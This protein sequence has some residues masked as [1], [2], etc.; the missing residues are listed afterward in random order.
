MQNRRLR[1]QIFPAPEKQRSTETNAHNRKIIMLEKFSKLK[2]TKL[3]LHTKAVLYL[4]IKGIVV[5]PV[6]FQQ[7]LLASHSCFSVLEPTLSSPRPPVL[8]PSLVL[9]PRPP[10]PTHP[11]KP[12][13]PPPRTPHPHASPTPP[14]PPPSLLLHGVRAYNTNCSFTD[15]RTSRVRHN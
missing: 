9:D 12:T 1:K 5:K 7:N 13:P 3:R 14:R 2:K 10:P 6:N 15:R 11:P 8:P 4:I